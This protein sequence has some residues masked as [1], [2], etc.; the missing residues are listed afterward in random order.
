MAYG[1]GDPT[2]VPAVLL[3]VSLLL[4]GRWALTTIVSLLL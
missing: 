2:T 1:E 4:Y 3:H